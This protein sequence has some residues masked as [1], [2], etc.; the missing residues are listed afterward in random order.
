MTSEQPTEAY[1]WVWLPGAPRP[2]VAGRLEAV[3]DILNFNYGR[4]YLD[5]DD[6]I[7]IYAPEARHFGAGC[8][9]RLRA[10]G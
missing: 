2:V 7:A 3:G 1:V 6:A 9:H 8:F 4:G 10:R 5:S